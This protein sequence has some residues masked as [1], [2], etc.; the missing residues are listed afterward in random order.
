MKNIHIVNAIFNDAWFISLGG[1]M[2]QIRLVVDSVLDPRLQ[3]QDMAP[4]MSEPQTSGRVAIMPIIGILT[5]YDGACGT[6]GYQ[7]YG[8]TINTLIADPAIDAIILKVDSPGGQASGLEGLSAIIS[9]SPKPIVGYVDDQGCSAA[10]GILSACGAIVANSEMATVGSIGVMATYTDYTEAD[11]RRGV[12]THSIYAPQSSDKNKKARLIEQ[13]DTSAVEEEL[14]V[15]ADSFIN[16]IKTTRPKVDNSQTTGNTYF[17]KDVIG[18]LVDQI[19]SI[20][21]AAEIALSLITTNKTTNLPTPTTRIAAALGVEAIETQD[22]Y[23][24][25]SQEQLAAIEAG[26]EARAAAETTHEAAIAAYQTALNTVTAERDNLLAEITTLKSKPATT[27]SAVS[28]AADSGAVA[29]GVTQ[30]SAEAEAKKY[31]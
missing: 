18:T 15:V 22:G 20:N 10:Y 4:G 19:G 14:R 11:R 3:A 17:A 13:G 28:V 1:N 16:S 2:D 21:D 29:T 8:K 27:H 26:I 30:A 7:T 24:S 25:F 9:Q 23:A 12:K 5:K 31:L 6:P